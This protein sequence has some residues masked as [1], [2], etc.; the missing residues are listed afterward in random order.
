MRYFIAVA[1]RLSFSRAAH[2]L[3]VT[4]PPLSRHVRQL[5][6]EFGVPLF[7][8]DRRRVALTDAGRMLL[9]ES[10]ILMAQTEHLSDSLR[11]AKKGEVGLVRLG[12][13]L[14][15]GERI[16]SVLLEHS[17]QYP[18]VD[19]QC[20]ESYSSVQNEALLEGELDVGFLRPPIDLVHVVSEPLFEEGLAVH[21]SKSNPLAKRK[22]LRMRDLAGEPLLLPS[23]NTSS[24]LY[25]K[26]LALYNSAGV[27]PNIIPLAT[28]PLPHGDIQAILLACRK[29]I[30]IM[31]DEV[32]C[33]PAPGSEVVAVPL[34]EPEAKVEVRMAWRRN[35][36]SAVVG[37]FLNTAR[38]V[39]QGTAGSLTVMRAKAASAG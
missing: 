25:R 22:F 27:T 19:I 5:E 8:R 16:S 34:D 21:I 12:I 7:V 20:K 33:R 10:K 31:P 3:H 37:A 38:R 11:L 9:R 4:V 13:G 36:R 1:E 39:F 14:G 17:K 15:L 18:A 28:T 2:H 32:A 35:E 24:G 6:E 30:F 29:G 23:R 26:T